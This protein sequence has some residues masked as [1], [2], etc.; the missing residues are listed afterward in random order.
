[1]KI[2][3]FADV[4]ARDKDL[5]E[6][7][8]CLGEIVQ[9]AERENPDLITMAGDTFDSRM[10]RL[11]SQAAKLIFEVYSKLADIAPMIVI[12]GTPSHDG[13][14]PQVLENVRSRY[15]VYVSDYPEQIYLAEGDLSTSL[16]RIN[17]PTEAPLEA[18]ISTIPTPTKQYWEKYGGEGRSAK[19]TDAEVAE[20]MGA[21]L[22]N[23][24]AVAAEFDCPHILVGHFQVGGAFLSETQQLIGQ[25]IELSR[26]QIGFAGA[27][28]V[29]LG[30]IH[31]PQ[32]IEP[33]IF[34]SGSIYTKDF[35]ELHDHGFYIHK[36]NTDMGNPNKDMWSLNSEFMQTPV[37]KLIK[38]KKDFTRNGGRSAQEIIGEG[39]EHD[40]TGAFVR[41]EIKVWQ[42]EADALDMAAI[43]EA[44]SA[45]ADVDLKIQRVPRETVR[46][47][48]LLEL[49]TLRDKIRE[50]A[51]LR[52][53]EVP[54]TILAKADMLERLEAD[55]VCKAVANA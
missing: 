13:L 47:A 54:E 15:P 16:E 2:F 45:A 5:P 28:L 32:K 40:V 51:L 30:H 36:I 43:T 22:A 14:A 7:A 39:F 41:F 24:G 29:A 31:Y 11:D 53:E 37:R 38:I 42:D 9:T 8:E 46:A 6:I 25:D 17:A 21:M 3:H 55:E 52:K 4:H 48:K 33:N 20:A 35:G 18:V 23:F 44:L 34:Y 10:V 1:M 19:E 49:Q 27:D 50:M 12:T 26:D